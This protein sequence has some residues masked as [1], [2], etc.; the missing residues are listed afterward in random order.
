VKFTLET[1]DANLVGAWESG[2]VRIGKEWIRGHLIVSPHSILRDWAVTEPQA[3]QV[4]D[5]LP[6]MEL[7][8]NII[9]L[10]T[11]ANLVLPQADLMAAL[12]EHRV[13]LEIMDTPAACRTYN[14]LVHEHRS[15]AAALFNGV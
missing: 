8:P 9:L 12:A 15:V 13:G 3:L 2:A 7:Q 4:S 10:G 14:V 6:A 5:L 11:G 1:S